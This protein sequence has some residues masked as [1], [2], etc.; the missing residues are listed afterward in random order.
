M[1]LLADVALMPGGIIAWL[2]VGLFAGWMAGMA[3]KGGG[4]GIVAD[5]FL[6]LVGALIGGF[7]S[8]FFIQGAIGFMGSVIIAAL[9]ACLLIA[10][11]RAISPRQYRA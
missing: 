8:A 3:M 9:G 4:Y 1:N 5:I 11:V 7:V 2:F 10:I 6:G